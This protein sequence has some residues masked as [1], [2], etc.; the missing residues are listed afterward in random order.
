MGLSFYLPVAAPVRARGQDSG[1]PRALAV[2]QELFQAE[3]YAEA[4]GACQ[5]ALA[6]EPSSPVIQNAAGV[7]LCKLGRPEEAIAVFRQALAA[8]PGNANLLANLGNACQ[9]SLQY[10]PAEE[11]H[12]LALSLA[13][14]NFRYLGNLADVLARRG[15]VA[16]AEKL[17]REGLALAPQ[18]PA[19]RW[20]LATT[21][22]RGG[23]FQ[24]GWPHYEWRWHLHPKN[25]PR[26][27][28]KP[29]WSGEALAGR[30]LLLYCEQG[31][32]DTMHC[33]RYVAPVKAR[34]GKVIL[35][36]HPELV[37]L[38]QGLAGADQVIARGGQA[39]PDF[40]LHYPLLSC[41]MLFTPTPE[42]VPRDLPYLPY[43]AQAVAKF[44]PAFAPHAGKLKVGIVWS[45]SPDF[46]ENRHRSVALEALAEALTLEGVQLFSLQKGPAAQD[47]GKLANK[48]RVIDLAAHFQD[49]ADTA[50]ALRHLDLIVMTDTSVAHLAGALGKPVCLLLPFFA[51]WVW[52]GR[53]R[54]ACVWYPSLRLLRQSTP[55]DWSVPLAEAQAQVRALLAGGG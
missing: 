42:E 43:P 30:R 19:L 11:A 14:G 48:G 20:G 18:D 46:P 55:G 10:G 41:P 22:L 51:H 5:A 53:D 15:Q 3:K 38:C 35:E 4:W 12:R 40:D 52:G 17:Y 50:G 28:A 33:L 25:P 32:G 23:R 31:L 26:Q 24:E 9:E 34:G 44:A 47:L 37:G 29:R 1:F 36:V 54:A 21:L 8:M 7:I 39:P 27:L 2:C 6:L 13:P 45:G 49:F 16:E